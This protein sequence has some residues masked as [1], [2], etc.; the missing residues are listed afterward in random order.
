ML[1]FG[2]CSSGSTEG[3]RS[4]PDGG[5]GHGGSGTGGAVGTPPAGGE[6]ASSSG[7]SGGGPVVDTGAPEAS[8]STDGPMST[9]DAPSSGNG[10]G[11]V[12]GLEDLSTVK[13]SPGCGMPAPQMDT[14]WHVYTMTTPMTRLGSLMRNYYLKLPP[15]YDNMKPY[16]LIFQ[17]TNC[18][19]CPTCVM[20]FDTVAG[21]EGVIQVA[22]ERRA[23]S[24]CFD[25]QSPMSVDFPFAEAAD[26]EL[27][28]KICFDEHR[29]FINGHSSGSWLTN[30]V[31]C[32]Y[33]SAPQPGPAPPGG[34]L[35]IRA[36]APHSGGLPATTP[37]S[38]RPMP[39]MWT[40][41]HD[42][43]MNNFMGSVNAI[44]RALKVNGCMGTYGNSPIAPYAAPGTNNTCHIYTSCP[45]EFPIILCDPAT[46]GHEGNKF[47]EANWQFFM[48]F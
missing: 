5:G 9:G 37:C 33:A 24:G 21:A 17:G 32:I 34:P 2:A 3:G 15:N 7:G 13:K 43:P 28:G 42:D 12:M 36:I 22:L 8:T 44:N 26:G 27:R 18:T 19:G 1:A 10:Y 23:G 29:V 38:T 46:G 16:R 47:Y 25:D 4:T 41:N 31:G 30:E 48:S 6:D 45:K 40:H 20:P 39:G 11:G 35:V 14:A